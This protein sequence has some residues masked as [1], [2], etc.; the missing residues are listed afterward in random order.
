VDDDD[1]RKIPAQY[2][3]EL[4]LFYEANARWLFGHTYLRAQRDRELAE[5]LVQDAFVAAACSWET[6]RELAPAQQR[7]WLRSTLSHKGTD[8][9]RRR[10]VLRRKQ[11]ELRRKYQVPEPDPERKAAVGSEVHRGGRADHRR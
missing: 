7:A 6:L 3:A 10:A 2:A 11:A 4:A 5:D 1:D 8:Y 9:F